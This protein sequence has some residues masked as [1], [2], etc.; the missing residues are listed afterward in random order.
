MSQR[1]LSEQD[2]FWMGLPQGSR[3]HS[4]K[5]QPRPGRPILPHYGNLGMLLG[6]Q[7]IG[8]PTLVSAFHYSL[9]RGER[10]I[11][12]GTRVSD[13]QASLFPT[14]LLAFGTISYQ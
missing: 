13:A 9:D 4:R 11:V 8:K 6:G 7:L 12:R 14:F 10:Q 1:L 3:K 2:G 5:R